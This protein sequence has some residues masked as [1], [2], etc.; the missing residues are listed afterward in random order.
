[1]PP[2]PKPRCGGRRPRHERL[3]RV[4]LGLV[5]AG[6]VLGQ[7]SVGRFVPEPWPTP[8]PVAEMSEQEFLSQM[9]YP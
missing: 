2:L 7:V 4:G 3:F 5:V 1:M 8:E 9:T 6:I